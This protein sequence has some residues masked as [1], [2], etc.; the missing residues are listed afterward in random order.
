VVSPGSARRADAGRRGCWAGFGAHSSHT[1]CHVLVRVLCGGC[2]GLAGAR[3]AL[4][5]GVCAGGGEDWG[6]RELRRVGPPQWPHGSIW[7]AG[8]TPGLLGE[9]TAAIDFSHVRQ[10]NHISQN[11]QAAAG[12]AWSALL[13]HAGRKGV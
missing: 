3:W 11:I 7:R 2:A 5:G 13:L 9:Y 10:I 8:K 6:G 1:A 4:R 12:G